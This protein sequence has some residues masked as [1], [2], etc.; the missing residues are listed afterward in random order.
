M[1]RVLKIIITTLNCIQKTIESQFSQQG[2]VLMG[3]QQNAK[4][5]L[6]ILD[7]LLPNDFQGQL[8]VESTA[9]HFQI[10]SD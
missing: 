1:S 8:H 5:Y 4:I 6:Y 7:L 2:S 10:G 3:V 9:V